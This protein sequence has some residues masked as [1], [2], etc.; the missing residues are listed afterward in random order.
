MNKSKWA[1]SWFRTLELTM[2]ALIALD[3]YHNAFFWTVWGLGL[4]I[5]RV[6]DLKEKGEVK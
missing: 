6:I 4:L 5:D 2:I 3:R 1:R